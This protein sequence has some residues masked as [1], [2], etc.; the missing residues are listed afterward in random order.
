MQR[1]IDPVTAVQTLGKRLV[2]LQID[3]SRQPGGEGSDVLAPLLERVRHLGVTPIM[4]GTEASRSV[5][6]FNQ[7]TVQLAEKGVS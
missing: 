6:L 3:P 4:F 1:G 2:T 5:S 7:V